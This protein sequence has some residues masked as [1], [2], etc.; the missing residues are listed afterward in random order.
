MSSTISK[1]QIDLL[2]AEFRDYL[3]DTHPDWTESTVSTGMSDAFFGLNN[4]SMQ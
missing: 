2:R 3:R 1:Q 4:K